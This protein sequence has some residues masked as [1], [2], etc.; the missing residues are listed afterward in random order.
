MKFIYS[1]YSF[2]ILM[3]LPTGVL[4]QDEKFPPVKVSIYAFEHNKKHK[5]IFLESPKETPYEITLSKANILGPF[6]TVRDQN[7]KVTIRKKE[8][9]AEG[10]IVY[11]PILKV[12]I[13]ANIKE[14][15]LILLPA[16]GEKSY[17]AYVIDQ[18]RRKFPNG[19]YKIFNLSSSLIR[20]LVGKTRVNVSPGKLF[21]FNPS[22]NVEDIMDVH[23]QYMKAEKWKT[24][25]RSRWVK[26][27]EK[28]TLL[29]V[30]VDPRTK[31]MKI[32]GV[33]M[34]SIQPLRDR[35]QPEKVAGKP[36]EN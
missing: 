23:F 8:V 25:G 27:Q 26:V 6:K 15:L 30:Y 12:T 29:C 20:G 17:K 34:K 10:G 22:S 5:T 18:S 4:A 36:L 16:A 19:S 32:R 28:R 21:S 11:T 9:N 13:G 7:G 33:N 35:K 1:V 14:P 24:F 3:L 31:R 2:L